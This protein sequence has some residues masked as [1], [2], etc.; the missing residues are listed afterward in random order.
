MEKLGEI[1]NIKILISGRTQSFGIDVNKTIRL[2]ELS[3]IICQ[4]FCFNIDDIKLILNN[5]PFEKLKDQ[6]LATIITKEKKTHVII[7]FIEK[8]GKYFI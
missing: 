7:Y 5:K 4:K 2:S 8:E 6:S 1:I 3:N